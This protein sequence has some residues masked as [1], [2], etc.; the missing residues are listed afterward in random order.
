MHSGT[1]GRRLWKHGLHS[2]SFRADAAAVRELLAE[3]A[4]LIAQVSQP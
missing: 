1:R 2:V 4:A 3:I